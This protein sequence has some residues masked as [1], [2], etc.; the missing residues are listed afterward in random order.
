LTLYVEREPL[1]NVSVAK[2]KLGIL[3]T[4]RK[5]AEETEEPEN[6]DGQ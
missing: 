1:N 2:Q 6:L 5:E 3:G 4:A